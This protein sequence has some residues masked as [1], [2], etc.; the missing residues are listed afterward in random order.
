MAAGIFFIVSPPLSPLAL[1]LSPF[2]LSP[3][4]SFSCFLNEMRMRNWAYRRKREK[5]RFTVSLLWCT[6]RRS[7]WKKSHKPVKKHEVSGPEKMGE[8]RRRR[9]GESRKERKRERER[10]RERGS[11]IAK[12]IPLMTNHAWF[13]FVC[14]LSTSLPPASPPRLYPTVPMC[15]SSPSF[16]PFLCFF[17]SSLASSSYSFAS[18][19]L[20]H[21]PI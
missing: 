15:V 3:S 20:S 1:S 11:S 9:R 13:S 18:L 14:L 17:P 7:A 5:R 10:E 6:T 4:I 19:N 21:L 12:G 8:M 16:R 2:P